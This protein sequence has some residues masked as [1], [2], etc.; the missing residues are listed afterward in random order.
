MTEPSEAHPEDRPR[1]GRHDS[2]P[3]GMD[4][5]ETR[6]AAPPSGSDSSDGCASSGSGSTPPSSQATS[7]SQ[8]TAPPLPD[9]IGPY[10]V[11]GLLGEGGM[12][13]VY[14]A[15]QRDALVREVAIKVVK[16]GMTTAEGLARFETER[17]ALARFDHPA[18][19]QVFDAGTTRAG[20]PYLVMERVVGR[21]ITDYAMEEQLDLGA[22]LDLFSRICRAVQHVHDR[23]FL[24]RDL[25]PSNLLIAK[26]SEGPRV[27]LID[28]GLA[29]AIGSA[30]IQPR[31]DETALH[32]QYGQLLGTLEYMS[33]EQAAGELDL[34]ERSDVYSLGAVLYELTTGTLPYFDRRQ[35]PIPYHEAQARL[36]DTDLER[37][38][39]RLGKLG[40]SA[41]A[42]ARSCRLD[43][44]LL[45][46]R[47]R[48][49]LDWI[50]TKSLDA[51]RHLRYDSP[52][53]LAEDLERHERHL[54]IQAGP[55]SV[56]A[57]AR[58]WVRRHRFSTTLGLTLVVGLGAGVLLAQPNASKDASKAGPDVTAYA[59]RF[60]TIDRNG[61]ALP[62]P[63]QVKRLFEQPSI[64]NAEYLTYYR[65]LSEFHELQ[66]VVGFTVPS[67]Y[68]E[69]F[70]CVRDLDRPE[71]LNSIGSSG[72]E[73]DLLKRRLSE[74]FLDWLREYD[75]RDDSTEALQLEALL[76]AFFEHYDAMEEAAQ[77][78]ASALEATDDIQSKSGLDE[79]A[80]AAAQLRAVPAEY[81]DSFYQVRR[82]GVESRYFTA[83]LDRASELTEVDRIGEAADLVVQAKR[84]DP[85]YRQEAGGQA[86]LRALEEQVEGYREWR[87]LQQN[88]RR[89]AAS[90]QDHETNPKVSRDDLRRLLL[91]LLE[92]NHSRLPA[93]VRYKAKQL[94]QDIT[95]NLD[96]WLV[97]QHELHLLSPGDAAHPAPT[98]PVIDGS[99]ERAQK[100]A[101]MAKSMKLWSVAE[102]AL[103]ELAR[104]Q[105]RDGA[106]RDCLQ[107]LHR[108][109]IN[110][111]P[112]VLDPTSSSDVPP[113][114]PLRL[115]ERSLEALC[116]A[117]LGEDWKAQARFEHLHPSDLRAIGESAVWTAAAT[118]LRTG[119]IG[120]AWDLL[121]A[122]PALLDR[123]PGR[124]P[125][126]TEFLLATR[127]ALSERPSVA[128]ELQIHGI[129]A[130]LEP[131]NPRHLRASMNGHARLAEEAEQ[132]G[133]RG[134]RSRAARH[135]RRESHRALVAF[136]DRGGSLADL[137]ESERQLAARLSASFEDYLPL[138]KGQVW[139]YRGNQGRN[140]T[141]RL[142]E[143]NTKKRG[144]TY[145]VDI[146]TGD[147]SRQERWATSRHSAW[148]RRGDREG[149]ALRPLLKRWTPGRELGQPSRLGQQNVSIEAIGV[150]IAT[151]AGTFANCIVIQCKGP[152]GIETTTLAPDVGIVRVVDG[153]TGEV[154]TLESTRP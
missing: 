38:S 15:E 69:L 117:Q 79:V 122:D 144:A 43:S 77:V 16:P 128:E 87:R 63:G 72:S 149:K 7:A 75:P 146:Q 140:R 44:S 33:P 34:D 139:S 142:V 6:I 131:L 23:G 19:A 67:L 85:I 132:A 129:L 66:C 24:H 121:H 123:R 81:H 4:P 52:R 1:E 89:L 56:S 101:S 64:T 126:P 11:I 22:R 108:I 35:G 31:P 124:A 78:S 90:M 125:V 83:L 106:Y 114:P 116:L 103:R 55:P 153:K 29:K 74:K 93:A 40:E 137:D 92:E 86:R 130:R 58:K 99:A 134:L 59:D 111:T 20:R 32:T 148:I 151:P 62:E 18:I 119:A 143:D 13:Y 25:K 50:V 2:Q 98:G 100:V 70:D 17:Q 82:R 54:P 26:S 120:R 109:Q 80:R 96:G 73:S 47:L 10:R 71:K 112:P 88:V 53:A 84:I 8:A 14:L 36:R 118:H 61:Y 154:F 3:D 12:G 152:S 39:S 37:P 115:P 51:D 136:L 91:A 41:R 97:G 27:K 138:K 48:G 141:V 95:H 76:V 107:T 68:V 21:P 133:P 147:E 28:F 42:H 49:D 105:Y 150:T 94:E 127:T 45:L 104:E 110:H 65:I 46:R 102:P 135:H 9:W 145:V 113:A 60:T 5:L 30:G 57:R